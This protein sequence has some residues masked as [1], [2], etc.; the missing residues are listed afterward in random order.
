M[1]VVASCIASAKNR[2]QEE[3]TQGASTVRAK[4]VAKP[5]Q[6]PKPTKAAGLPKP[7]KA[8]AKVRKLHNIMQVLCEC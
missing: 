4:R 5:A 3:G 2:V 8:T 7:A 1:N 6:T